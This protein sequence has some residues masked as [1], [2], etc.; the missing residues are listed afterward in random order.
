MS[1]YQIEQDPDPKLSTQAC[2]F[3]ND[4]DLRSGPSLDSSDFLNLKMIEKSPVKAQRQ[5]LIIHLTKELLVSRII[6]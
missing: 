4:L 3:M 6:I 2:K 1:K 5:A